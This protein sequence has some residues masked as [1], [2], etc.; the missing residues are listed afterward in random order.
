[1][2]NIIKITETHVKYS[3]LLLLLSCAPEEPKVTGADI[4]NNYNDALCDVMSQ[5]ECG[6]N[7]ANCGSSVVI[8][9]SHEMCIQAQNSLS[10]GCETLETN[11]LNAQETIE[12]CFEI[13]N[14]AST[15]CAESYLCPD[16]VS[17]LKEGS[18]A[19]VQDIFRQ[20][21]L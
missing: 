4:L 18:C 12:N 8:F 10:E 16:G 7:L 9:S 14:A 15:N 5:S 21:N 13:L 19:E 11:V 20:C 1:M 2:K 6:V 17:F 3:T